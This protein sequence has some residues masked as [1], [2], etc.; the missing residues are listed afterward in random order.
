MF[1]TQLHVKSWP[2]GVVSYCKSTYGN[3]QLHLATLACTC[4]NSRWL[5]VT[6]NK[7]KSTCKLVQIFHCLDTQRKLMQVGLS[8]VFNGMSVHA[9]L[10]WNGFLW[11]ASNLLLLTIPYG[12]P[13]QVCV[14][15]LALPNLR[16]WLVTSIGQG[17]TCTKY[18]DL[19]HSRIFKVF[20]LLDWL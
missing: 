11:L 3:L 12:H 5:A 7:L 13:T 2:N 10:H 6:L 9:R 17:H 20:S 1:L 18:N 16:Q 14:C 8:I 19:I 15:K 4:H